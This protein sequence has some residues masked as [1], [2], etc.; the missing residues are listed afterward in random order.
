MEIEER[1]KAILSILVD[2]G[3]V[4]VRDLGRRFAVS[5]DTIRRDLEVLSGQGFLQ[6][7]HGG[8]VS[9]DVPSIRREVRG[10]IAGD[11][12][13]KIGEMAAEHLTPGATLVID[14]GQT[15][16]EVARRLPPGPFTVITLSLDVALALSHRKDIRLIVVGGEWNAEQ[17]LFRGAATIETIGSY[18]AT[19]A[20]MGACAVDPVFGVTA[21]EEWDGAAKRAM[22][23]ISE[24]RMLVA[25]HT[26]F[27]RREPFFVAALE[28]FDLFMSDQETPPKNASATRSAEPLAG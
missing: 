27:G 11:A 24:R 7:T 3:H 17:R 16:L 28:E 22:M 14:A 12:K 8:A 1:R 26:K 21:S 18:R 2:A 20:V 15:T 23:R 9:L 4:R 19:L 5:D 6:K 10:H 13:A 25:D